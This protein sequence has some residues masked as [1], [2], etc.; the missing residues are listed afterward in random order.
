MASY[1]SYR[2]SHKNHAKGIDY[3]DFYQ[4]HSWTKFVWE[5]EQKVLSDILKKYFQND[6]IHL[7]DFACGTG[8]ITKFLENKVDTSIGVDISKPMLDIA[9]KKLEK[10]K[11]I[12]VDLTKSNPFKWQHFNLI[13]AFRF[14][15][16]SEPKLRDEVLT[17]ITSL[18]SNDGYFIF[19][20]HLNWASPSV[21]LRY[22]YGKFI[23]KDTCNV[24]S[25]DAIKIMLLKHNL[26]IIKVY[27]IGFINP[28]KVNLPKLWNIKIDNFVK[29][30]KIFNN[31]SE[32]PIFVCK[33]N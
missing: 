3:D 19:N 24:L 28:I 26:E 21:K 10:T 18:L 11:L 22:Y 15:L 6:K 13:T 8:R 1:N 31:C 5:Q 2:E 23:S 9:K 32:S 14:F 20:N 7:L 12:R 27:P 16:N 4:H 30:I 17:I 25:I 29:N 33:H